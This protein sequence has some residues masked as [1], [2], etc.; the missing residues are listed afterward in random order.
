[1]RYSSEKVQRYSRAEDE[2]I[3]HY[4]VIKNAFNRVGGIKLWKDMEMEV[5]E[6]RTWRSLKCRF[7][8]SLIRAI[9]KGET[10]NLTAEQI[11]FF[12]NGGQIEEAGE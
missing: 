3:L 6:G 12:I 7:H 1:M 8:R 10:Y 5:L 4:I 9:G 11:A 2:M